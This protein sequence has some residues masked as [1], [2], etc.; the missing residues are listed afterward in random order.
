[1]K[2]SLAPR[3]ITCPRCG[4]DYLYDPADLARC[5]GCCD[6]PVDWALA[7]LEAEARSRQVPILVGEVTSI[8]EAGPILLREILPAGE[9]PGRLNPSS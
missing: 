4:L 8:G 6:G 1:M 2:T 9:T 5:P 7:R 3:A